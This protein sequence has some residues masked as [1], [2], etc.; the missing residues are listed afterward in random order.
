[1]WNVSFTLIPPAACRIE[2]FKRQAD[3]LHQLMATR[4]RRICPVLRHA[5]AHRKNFAHRIIFGERRYVRGRRRRWRAEDILEHPLSTLNRR[6]AVRV[7]SHS[8]NASLPKEPAA[9]A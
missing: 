9:N 3:R 1:T 4:A 5:F 7:G 6:G 2:V 8:E